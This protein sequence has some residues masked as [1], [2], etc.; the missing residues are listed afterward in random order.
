MFHDRRLRFNK[1]QE[2]LL[3][4]IFGQHPLAADLSVHLHDIEDR[5]I[6]Q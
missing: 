1:G 2:L 3:V 6:D 4:F 5:L